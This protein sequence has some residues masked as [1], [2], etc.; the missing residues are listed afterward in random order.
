M[1]FTMSTRHAILG[2][3][4]QGP[5]HGYR[6]KKIFSPFVSKDGLND[7]Q[8]YPLLTHLE[9]QKLVRKETVRQEK[10]PN[11]NLYHITDRGREEFLRWLTGDE[12]ETDPV[13][14]DF[15][16]QYSFLM[17]CT[18]FEHLSPHERIAKLRRQ[19][20]TAN[21]KIREYGRMREEMKERGLNSHKLRIVDFG[22]AVQ[23]LKVQWA[24]ELLEAETRALAR[25]R[26]SRGRSKT[27]RPGAA[28]AKYRSLGRGSNRPAK[29]G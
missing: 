13:K 5:A 22:V 29:K 18:F 21:G 19:I 9:G 25:K 1:G 26:V 16:M 2:V 27:N 20:E 6:I 15:F 3:L 7:G 17:K 14:Y 8:L 4:M 11:K 12:D 24:S 23:R 10:S 28:T